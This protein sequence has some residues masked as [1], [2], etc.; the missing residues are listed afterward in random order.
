MY[1]IYTYIT[2]I[3]TGVL[4]N[5]IEM[6]PV[7]YMMTQIFWGGVVIPLIIYSSHVTISF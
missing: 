5:E 1:C 6:L 7:E 4:R 2:T 3:L